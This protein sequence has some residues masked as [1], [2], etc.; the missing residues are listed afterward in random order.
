MVG[1]GE[2]NMEELC[3]QEGPTGPWLLSGLEGGLHGWLD[4]EIYDTEASQVALVA[5]LG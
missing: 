2:G 5:S 1:W 4:L 3:A